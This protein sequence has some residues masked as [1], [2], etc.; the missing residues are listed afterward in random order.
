M[1][2]KHPATRIASLTLSTL[3]VFTTAVS[4]APATINATDVKLREN[5][6]TSAKILDVLDKDTALNV[7]GTQGDWVQ[8]KQGE[9]SGYVFSRYVTLTDT[10]VA[11]AAPSTVAKIGR[12]SWRERV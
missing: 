5:P 4:A 12:A 7:L 1:S 11:A 9:V 6:T 8:V 3:L 2:R 10:P